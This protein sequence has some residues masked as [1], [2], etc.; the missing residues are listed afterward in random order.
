MIRCLA[1]SQGKY[2]PSSRFRVHQI[3]E[4]INLSPEIGL[5]MDTSAAKFGAY[6]PL[7][8]SRRPAWI[9]K[10]L[11]DAFKRASAAKE[12][13]ICLI[14]RE[15][16]STLYTG[17]ILI[18]I[19]YVF[20]IDDAIWRTS[21]FGSIERIVK[22]AR[23]TIV[24]NEYIANRLSKI[25]D[26]IKI[27]PTGVDTYKFAPTLG[28]RDKVIV[29]SGS[30]SG[31]P[32][33]YEIE[34]ELYKVLQKFQDW[35]LRILCDQ[36]PKFRFLTVEM[37]EYV[38]WSISNEVT[39]VNTA[40][41]GI[42]PLPDN[43]WERAKCSYKML[44]YMSC[45]LPVVVSPVGMNARVLALAK[46][47]LSATLDAEWYDCLGHLMEDSNSGRAMG[48]NGRQVISNH[49]NIQDIALEVAN[50]LKEVLA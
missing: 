19:P 24:G 15:M 31:L 48:V 47:G 5:T 4:I 10:A 38:K 3:A 11:F 30:S 50:T 45:G 28:D 42:M 12:Y 36:P 1:F 29:W 34:E 13:D 41:I 40:S 49:F 32:Y 26:S 35:K 23:L 43:D 39:M 44:T 6:P 20:D 18:N 16:V 7:E 14:H 22:R 25:T 8:A 27:I 46:V 9:L 21:R 17:E 2:S 37:V 33:V